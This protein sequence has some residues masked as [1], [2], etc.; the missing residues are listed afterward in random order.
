M[1][2]KKEQIVFIVAVAVLGFMAA[3]HSG[4]L[5]ALVYPSSKVSPPFASGSSPAHHNCSVFAM[6]S[7]RFGCRGAS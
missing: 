5:A 3:T 7:N 4:V 6:R 2:I 1:K